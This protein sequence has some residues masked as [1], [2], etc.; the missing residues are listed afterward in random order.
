[1]TAMV[2][3]LLYVYSLDQGMAGI[4]GQQFLG[5]FR[6]KTCKLKFYLKVPN[7]NL[8]GKLYIGRVPP[9]WPVSLCCSRAW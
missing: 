2:P 8:T 5:N 3:V 4:L 1:M 7:L 6:G 9:R